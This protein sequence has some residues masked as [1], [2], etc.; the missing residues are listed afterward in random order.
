MIYI[1][2]VTTKSFMYL[3]GNELIVSGKGG[4]KTDIDVIN[5]KVIFRV[6]FLCR[7]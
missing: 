4:L 5:Y 6:I 3:K 7:Y 1:I 2:D